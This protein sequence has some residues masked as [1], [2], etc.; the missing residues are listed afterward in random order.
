MSFTSIATYLKQTLSIINL[1]S[2]MS[3]SATMSIK[4]SIIAK[5]SFILFFRRRKKYAPK[6]LLDQ[7]DGSGIFNAV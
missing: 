7:Y 4:L 3:G 1:N 6:A 5:W 2:W